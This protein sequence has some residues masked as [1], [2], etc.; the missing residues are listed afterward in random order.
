MT[1]LDSSG[2]VFSTDDLPQKDRFANWCENFLRRYMALESVAMSDA[3]YVGRMEFRTCDAVAI[4][5]LDGAAGRFTRTRGLMTDGE[6]AF[7]LLLTRSGQINV[8]QNGHEATVETGGGIVLDSSR[9]FSVISREFVRSWAIKLSRRDLAPLIPGH[10]DLGGRKFEASDP[11]LRLLMGYLDSMP[12]LADMPGGPMQRV[13]GG[14]VLDLAGLALGPT[15]DALEVLS[16]GGV[17][18]AR[19]RSVKA[20][21]QNGLRQPDLSA[22]AV[23][24]REGISASYLRKL[25]ESDGTSFTAFVLGERLSKAHAMLS[26]PRFAGM[27]ISAIAFDVGFGDL[28]YFNRTFRRAFGASPSEVRDDARRSGF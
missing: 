18:A 21:I 10:D 15:P 25:L 19:L 26:D 11:A 28:S 1:S 6:D 3:P 22:D 24:L 23:A 27:T 9:P 4:G 20:R 5:A 12:P 17:R 8:T 16:Q 7:M 13:V 2:F 14:H